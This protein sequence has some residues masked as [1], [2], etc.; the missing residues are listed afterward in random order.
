MEMRIFGCPTKRKRW[1]SPFGH[2]LL[3]FLCISCC[4][5]SQS[6][7]PLCLFAHRA[8]VVTDSPAIEIAIFR[9][10]GPGVGAPTLSSRHHVIVRVPHHAAVMRM[11]RWP[12]TTFHTCGCSYSTSK[13]ELG[14][15]VP[16][17]P[18]SIIVHLPPVTPHLPVSLPPGRMITSGFRVSQPQR[19]M[20]PPGK[21]RA[22]APRS[23]SNLLPNQDEAF[24]M[25]A[26][27]R[28]DSTQ[29]QIGRCHL[30]AN[31]LPELS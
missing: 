1:I 23:S 2:G 31:Q 22:V 21:M 25:S 9:H 7:R 12:G 18:S 10:H 13:T 24:C 17:L 19:A 14:Y 27:N 30:A 16:H 4:S 8:F 29:I 5:D 26:A 20:T 11:R 3:V 15:W 28:P 6:L